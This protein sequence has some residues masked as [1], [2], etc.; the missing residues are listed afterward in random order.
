MIVGGKDR[1]SECEEDGREQAGKAGG[2]YR[3]RISLVQ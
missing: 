3:L 2:D 1:L